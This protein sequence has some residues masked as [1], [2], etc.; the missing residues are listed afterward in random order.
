MPRAAS[1]SLSE[2]GCAT[3]PDSV[4]GQR[5]E[6]YGRH[7]RIVKTDEFSSVFRLR[8]AFRTEHFA[9]YQR[10]NAL[11]HARLGVVVAKRLAQRAVTRNMIKRIAR[12]IF[13]RSALPGVDCIIRL[14]SPIVTRKDSASSSISKAALATELKQLLGK[15]Q[16]PDFQPAR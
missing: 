4:P 10:P 12:E 5:P 1:V 14:A 2:A 3:L 13:R 8:P 15:A 11:G 6:D 9:L 16:L 7:R